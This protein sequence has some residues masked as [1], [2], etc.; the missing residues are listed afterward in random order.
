MEISGFGHICS[1]SVNSWITQF[2]EQAINFGPMI[3]LPILEGLRRIAI[4]TLLGNSPNG[5]LLLGR[6]NCDPLFIRNYNISRMNLDTSTNDGLVQ[7]SWSLFSTWN[8]HNTTGK[9][10]KALGPNLCDIAD[11]TIDNKTSNTSLLCRGTDISPRNGIIEIASLDNNNC[12]DR[13]T[14]NGCMQHEIV[15]R[16]TADWISWTRNPWHLSPHLANSAV[17][18]L[19]AVKDIGVTCGR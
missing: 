9:N 16:C 19:A 17:H 7:R 14:V 2:F 11:Y 4:V 3:R 13:G 8:G 5:A 6:N 12:A 1:T 15:P 18:K 10:R